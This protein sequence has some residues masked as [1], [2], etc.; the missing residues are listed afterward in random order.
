[1][2]FIR[3]KLLHNKMKDDVLRWV[4]FG[5]KVYYFNVVTDFDLLKG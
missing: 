4:E 3:L 2:D 1:M 5:F